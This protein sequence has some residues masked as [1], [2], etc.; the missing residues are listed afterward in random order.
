MRKPVTASRAWIAVVGVLAIAAAAVAE[1][2][3]CQCPATA[4]SHKVG[5]PIL[6][7]VPYISRLFKNVGIATPPCANGECASGQCPVNVNETIE[8]IGVDF[9]FCVDSK[10][11]PCQACPVGKLAVCDAAGCKAIAVAAKAC[12]SECCAC[13]TCACEEKVA[14]A[15]CPFAKTVKNS[16]AKTDALWEKIVELS[17]GQAAAEAA[18]AGHKESLESSAGMLEVLAEVHAEKARLEAKLE[19]R[20]EHDQLTAQMLELATENIRLKAQVELAQAKA[21]VMEHTV[22][23]TVENERLKMRLAEVEK[24]PGERATRTAAR[25]KAEKKAR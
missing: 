15:A 19:A 5:V 11:A 10:D 12:G 8:W 4:A 3:K 20:E 6:S 2:P 17:A 9:D 16:T 14:V 24:Q 1:E 7:K 25:T 18:L 22:E 13:K 23:I 21:E